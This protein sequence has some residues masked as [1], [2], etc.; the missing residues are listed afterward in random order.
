MIITSTSEV[1]GTT[2]KVVIA[3]NNSLNAHH[4]SQ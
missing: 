2:Q 3:K 4:P 1:C